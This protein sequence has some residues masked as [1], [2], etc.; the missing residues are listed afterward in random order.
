[1]LNIEKLQEDGDVLWSL[2]NVLI[3]SKKQ[4]QEKELHGLLSSFIYLQHLITFS[5]SYEK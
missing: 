3:D 4:L 2:W 1:M 5:C